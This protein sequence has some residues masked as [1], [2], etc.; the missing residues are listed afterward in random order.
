LQH[1]EGD[2]VMIYSRHRLTAALAA[3]FACAL[4]I[5]GALAQSPSSG[6][7]PPTLLSAR[8]TDR[9][10]SL[11][12]LALQH[13]ARAR[14]L[15]QQPHRLPEIA[16]HLVA[17][18]TLVDLVRAARPTGKAQA[19]LEYLILELKQK[20][21]AEALPDFLP[22]YSALDKLGDAAVARDARGHLDDAKHALEGPDGGSARAALEAAQ[23]ALILD[24]IDLPLAAV[25]ADLE[26]AF[27]KLAS[28][29]APDDTVLASIERNLL[30]LVGLGSS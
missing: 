9:I 27:A 3:A 6:Q 22:I 15:S 14:T 25:D 21:N 17:T 19:L 5:G 30:V 24:T 11:A 7:T 13:V 12:A 2:N 16:D 26:T 29:S 18:R 4:V 8:Q 1:G 23:S 28:D 10:Q 20:D